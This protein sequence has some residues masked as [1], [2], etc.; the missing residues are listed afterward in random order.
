MCYEFVWDRKVD[1]VKRNVATHNIE[2]GGLGI[3]NIDVYIKSLKITWLKKCCN[4]NYSSKWKTILLNEIPVDTINM[5]GPRILLN[6]YTA[7]PFWK[8][9]FRSYLE[10]FNKVIIDKTE[11]FLLEPLFCNDKFK[12]N[13]KI[14]DFDA[15]TETGIY[16]VKDIVQENGKF[17]SHAV[18]I[19]VKHYSAIFVILWLC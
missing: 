10:F 18:S 16:L 4:P 9:V 1:K 6:N 12:I 14:M 19:K 2:H 5:Y 11:E 17:Y 3:P 13:N 15:W 7:N 8:D